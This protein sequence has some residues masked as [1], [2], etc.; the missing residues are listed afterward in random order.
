VLARSDRCLPS[1]AT[2]TKYFGSWNAALD[3]AGLP[4]VRIA[5]REWDRAQIATALRDF[6]RDHGHAPTGPQFRTIDDA[7]APNTVAAHF[8]SW[9]AALD[10]AG[11]GRPPPRLRWEHSTILAALRA[12]HAEHGRRPQARDFAHAEDRARWPNPGTVARHF[13]SWNNAVR[14][15][16]L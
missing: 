13:G 4:A 8:G 14:A 5:P 9:N 12:W 2:A 1:V 10:A 11:V 15:A 6:A 16:G 3:A 7:P